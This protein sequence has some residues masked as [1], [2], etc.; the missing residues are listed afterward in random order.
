MDL[1]TSECLCCWLCR[2]H[3]RERRGWSWWLLREQETLGWALTRGPDE[4][5]R[6]EEE[7]NLYGCSRLRHGAWGGS[8]EIQE[9]PKEGSVR[10]GPGA[11]AGPRNESAHAALQVRVTTSPGEA[12]AKRR[13]ELGTR[14]NSF[15]KLRRNSAQID[16]VLGKAAQRPTSRQG[17]LA[18]VPMPVSH[19][20]T[21]RVT[22][23][24]DHPSAMKK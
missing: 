4:E 1:S 10:P 17:R 3:P 24:A 18:P 11:G 9:G 15:S 6:K 13:G 22:V 5:R 7:I 21:G 14:R 23:D 20:L 19:R 16:K 8:V 2:L 12:P